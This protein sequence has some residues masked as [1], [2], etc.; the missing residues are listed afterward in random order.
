MLSALL[1]TV[2]VFVSVGLMLY[3]I[4]LL[5]NAASVPL[6]GF[7]ERQRF[8]RHA[9]RARK[10]D[11][12]LKQGAAE[13]ALRE[14]QSAFYL[15]AVHSRALAGSVTNHHTAL[16]SRLIALTADVQGGS[17][18]LLSLAK[19]DRLLTERSELQRRFFTARQ[20]TRGDSLREIQAQLDH[21]ARELSTTLQQL[22][23]EVA[24]VRQPPRYH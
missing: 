3:L 13:E 10:C 2:V 5:Y 17:V 9:A 11:Q 23:S 20:G 22:V 8:A 6:G 15:H 16:L 24:A 7:L 21:N 18:R 12:L 14:I 19:T 4:T 1:A